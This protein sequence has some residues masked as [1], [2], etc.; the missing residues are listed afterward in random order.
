[1]DNISESS[2][3]YNFPKG[4]QIT[5]T[6]DNNNISIAKPVPSKPPAVTRLS[7]SS[8][9]SIKQ[10]QPQLVTRSVELYTNRK[11]LKIKSDAD[12][13]ASE[14]SHIVLDPLEDKRGITRV[15]V[16]ELLSSTQANQ[17][18]IADLNSHMINH[19]VSLSDRNDKND[20]VD[21]E[22]LE[23]MISAGGNINC[24]DA[25][26]QTL[27]HEVIRCW[28]FE[29]Y[30]FFMDREADIFTLDNYDVSLL[31]VAAGKNRAEILKDLFKR[32][33]EKDKIRYFQYLQLGT[34][35]TKQNILHFAAKYDNAEV[36][37]IILSECKTHGLK[38]IDQKDKFGRT[39]LALA[40]DLDRSE[41][42]KILLEFNA[43]PT[44]RDKYGQL[45]L[46]SMIEKMPGIAIDALD[47]F[48]HTFRSKRKQH[49]FLGQIGRPVG[50]VEK[51][52]A[53]KKAHAKSVK[54]RKSIHEMKLDDDS[55]PVEGRLYPFEVAVEQRQRLVLQSP[56]MQE[57]IKQKWRMYGRK[58]AF[59][60]LF[61][62]AFL[63]IMWSITAIFNKSLPYLVCAEA[64]YI[65][66]L[67]IWVFAVLFNIYLIVKEI[68]EFTTSRQL[69]KKRAKFKES[70]LQ[71]SI[72][73]EHPRWPDNKIYYESQL[74]MVKKEGN[75]VVQA[76]FSDAWN[77]ID[78]IV[79][80]LLFTLTVIRL[81]DMFLPSEYREDTCN[82]RTVTCHV[83]DTKGYNNVSMDI[84]LN[85]VYS[86]NTG[87]CLS[88]WYNRLFSI[89]KLMTEPYRDLIPM[90]NKIIFLIFFSF[91]L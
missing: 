36:I 12:H 16:N 8:S 60:E 39:P 91:Q 15:N 5:S 26:G 19:F 42:A 20:E 69:T 70:V 46:V 81:T 49:F 33:Y 71:E 55:F 35:N 78:W 48:V 14:E 29:I 44:H 37:P 21:L 41:A 84:F 88:D 87:N 59:M 10:E 23:Q 43:N 17:Q 76:Y 6:D 75:N 38:I 61:S 73:A 74:E 54:R 11:R 52:Y 72:S 57:L 66:P 62:G 56:A 2:Y 65:I 80:G 13:D 7:N 27:S 22:F 90:P 68:Q 63:T 24:K 67:I 45:T 58:G 18:A 89:G 3:S 50:D 28:S 47:K 1:M 53:V 40:A 64:Q 82:R 32:M 9:P 30:E 86:V 85:A 51:I 4:L 31:H 79:Y 34:K 25:F 83:I 77:I